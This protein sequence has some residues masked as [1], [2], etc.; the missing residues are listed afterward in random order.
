M[1]GGRGSREG[2]IG[3][4]GAIEEEEEEFRASRPII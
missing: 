3:P 4:Q 2:A 1:T